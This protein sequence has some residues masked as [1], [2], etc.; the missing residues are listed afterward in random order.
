MKQLLKAL[1]YVPK[2][3]GVLAAALSVL[4]VPAV[5][6]AWG[7]TRTTFTVAHP[8]DYVTFNSIT[9]NPVDGDERN[10]VRAV[11]ASNVTSAGFKDDIAV[12][13]GK[14]YL[15]RM[16][17]HN[18]AADNLNL[19]AINTRVKTAIPAT[20]GKEVQISGFVSADNAKPTEVWDDVTFTGDKE[21]KLS[22]VAG[23][24]RIYNN[25]YAAGGSGQ[26]LPDDIASSTGTKIG[27][28]KAGDG[29]I[30]GCFKYLSYVEFKVK[31]TFETPANFDV[32]KTV[33]ISDTT[34][35]TWKETV[36]AKAGQK[37]DFQI[38]FTN[39]S[40]TTL[41][42]VVIRDMLPTGLTYVPGTTWLHNGGGTRQVADGVTTDGID[43][44]GY[45]PQGNAFVKFTAQVAANDKL[46]TCGPNTLKNI[47]SAE[48]SGSKKED[49][50]SVT[51]SKECVPEQPKPDTYVCTSL[52]KIQKSRD[53]YEFAVKA[54]YSD[55]VTVKEVRVDFGDTQS[56]IVDYGAT[57]PHTYAKPGTYTAVAYVTFDVNGKTVTGITS[58]ACKQTVEVVP[59]TVNECKPGIPA[60]DARCNETPTP[61]TTPE[62]P[63]EMPSTGPEA[64]IGGL[65]GSSALGLGA[66]SWLASRRAY[67]AAARR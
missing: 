9:D 3:Y 49:D 34:D 12:A 15:V 35:K 30:P 8:A 62:T 42:H 10:F 20:A 66:H 67:R 14:E 41:P 56:T 54:T 52:T 36:D 40:Q 46:P 19:K 45:V 53:T 2:R 11:D 23:S 58:D 63:A 47:A 5:L 6:M 38:E 17:V 1:R 22:Y 33:R 65:F 31:P 43:V 16:V 27:Y 55:K 13:D 4:A 29:I 28:E 57:I 21:F 25:G 26:P 59:P 51:V 61:P 18:N 39:T 50:A 48:T 64:L 37:V 24:A 44:G 32:K 60:G 7:P